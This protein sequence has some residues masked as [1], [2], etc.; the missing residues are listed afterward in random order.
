MKPLSPHWADVCAAKILRERGDK[1]EYVV[2]SGITP[3][4]LIHIGNFREV[5]TVDLVARALKALGKRVRFIYS[6]DNF[7]TFRK[8]PKNVPDPK[9]FEPY[10]RRPIARIPDPWGKGTSFAQGRTM[11]FE[12]ELSNVGIFPQY[13]YQEQKYSNGDYAQQVYDALNARQAIIE[14]LN[15]HRTEPLAS[16][17]LPTSIYC[18]KCESDQMAW[19]RYEG[20]WSYAYACKDCNFTET[21]DIRTTRNLKLV[22]RVD[23]PMRWHYE[24]VDFEPGGK[25]HSSQGGSFDTG[26]EIVK[27]VWNQTAPSYLQ[28]D[29]VRIKGG[30]GKM[31]SSSGELYTLGQV[32]KI[33][34]P[35][36]V[37][38]IFSNQRPN[39]DFAIAF[40]EDVIKIHDEFDRAE[41][42]VFDPKNEQEK[43]WTMQKRSYEFSLTESHPLERQ[44]KRASFRDLCNRLQICNLDIERTFARYYKD[45]ITENEDIAAFRLRAANVCNWLADYAPAVFRY[46]LREKAAK[47][48]LSPSQ[49]KAI[50]CLRNL[51]AEIDTETLSP[52]E[53]NEAIWDKVINPENLDAKEVFVAVYQK[54]IG[55]DQG[56]RLPS[57][58]KEI[59][60]KRVY[61]LLEEV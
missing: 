56:P 54:L 7:D 9:G 11:E 49:S 44:P 15:Q 26:K 20:G 30:A 29:F 57:F 27:I 46:S 48:D 37:R 40:D 34:E 17:W 59:G 45:E 61:E 6:W 18:G 43:T 16:D 47:V 39:H 31:S 2:A 50:H 13:L 12:A 38:W 14:L 55:R 3:S 52:K 1:E 33:Y 24:K 23:W 60:G 8:V 41:A 4:G 36:I 28:Y 53:I 19:E 5:I 42:F 10:L 32:L 58:I 22:W 25:D 35:Q 21:V 51:L